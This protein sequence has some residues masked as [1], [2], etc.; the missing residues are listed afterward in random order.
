MD[1]QAGRAAILVSMGALGL[2]AARRVLDQ[3]CAA[4][5]AL[6]AAG[7]DI[8][9]IAPMGASFTAALAADANAR[10][11]IVYVADNSGLEA[12]EVDGNPAAF[13]VG[14]SGRIVDI[15]PLDEDAD[16]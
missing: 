10:R 9:P 4:Q 2:D 8:V 7:V 13:Y 16:L 12:C 5:G 3:I 15:W 6:D 14:R 1:A 11:R